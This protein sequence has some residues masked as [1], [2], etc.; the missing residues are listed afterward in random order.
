M[1][2]RPQGK[3]LKHVLEGT[4]RGS[5]EAGRLGPQEKREGWIKDWVTRIEPSVLSTCDPE[6]LYPL[7][8][9][10]LETAHEAGNATV[11]T[12]QMNILRPRKIKQAGSRKS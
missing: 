2:P 3:G 1:F 7:P 8:H 11:P 6:P 10:N 4:E 5:L 12:L 9:L